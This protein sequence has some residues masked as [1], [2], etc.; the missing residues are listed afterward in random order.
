MRIVLS[1]KNTYIILFVLLAG[2]ILRIYQL[3]RYDLWYDESIRAIDAKP[4]FSLPALKKL[5]DR[6]FVIKYNQDYLALYN[7]SFVYYWQ[8]I[9]GSSESIL[10]FSSVLLGILTI[11][12][13][14]ILTKHLF[15]KRAAYIS[16]FLLSISPFHIHY[17]QELSPYVLISFFS[18]LSFYCFFRATVVNQKRYWLF[19][20][21][22][23]TLNIYNHYIALLLFFSL[24]L[25]LVIKY[26]RFKQ[27]LNPGLLTHAIILILIIPSLLTILPLLNFFLKY[28]IPFSF[29]EF[30]C[31]VEKINW[32]N[33]IFTIKNFSIGYHINFYSFVGFAATFVYLIFFM[34]GIFKHINTYTTQLVIFSLIFP[35]SV[36]FLISQIKAC[37]VYR[38]FFGLLP[39]FLIEVAMGLNRLRIFF[40]VPLL[41]FILVLNL[42]GLKNYY[43]DVLTSEYD[44]RIGVV[45]KLDG[46]ERLA[47]FISHTFREGDLILHTCKKT[48]YPLKFYINRDYNLFALTKEVNRGKVIYASEDRSHLMSV[49]Y[50]STHPRLVDLEEGRELA[51][52]PEVW[53]IFSS[54]TSRDVYKEDFPEYLMIELIKRDYIIKWHKDFG[55]LR[56]YS[57]TLKG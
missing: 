54:F 1:N 31:W 20:L 48:V 43:N 21:I 30:P 22:F 28:K 42:L 3:D 7:H 46:I 19:Y 39:F 24:L 11:Y 5:L 16:I 10:R 35:I 29:S 40:L 52:Y 45:E 18:C 41:A 6:E 25:F 2:S 53:L 4:L 44:Q 9:F 50:M 8:K 34:L 12:F 57:L 56:L 36:L 27:V 13:L 14:Y 32:Q 49:D 23:M 51:K 15:N 55:D 26:S 17:S 47:Q 33:I 37:Y 38:Y